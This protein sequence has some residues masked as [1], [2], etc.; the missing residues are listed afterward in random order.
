MAYDRL[1]MLGELGQ[2]F[3]IKAAGTISGGD[4]VR[5]SSGTDVVGSVASTYAWDDVAGLVASGTAGEH[6]E[7]IIGIAL[8]TVT[9]GTEVGIAMTGVFSLPTG[10]NGASG[11]MPVT[12]VGYAN[13]VEKV[14]TGSVALTEY[15][16]GRALSQSSANGQFTIVRL[17]V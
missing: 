14:S 15:G 10:S 4:L 9:S 7:N 12:F 1:V 11:G 8:D 13:C 3:T 5:W 17:N 2:R 16:I 6:V